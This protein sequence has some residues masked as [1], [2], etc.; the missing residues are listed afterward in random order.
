MLFRKEIKT[1]QKRKKRQNDNNN[2]K[3][4]KK[5]KKKKQPT[6]DLPMIKYTLCVERRLSL[7]PVIFLKNVLPDKDETIQVYHEEEVR[8]ALDVVMT[9]SVRRQFDAMCPLGRTVVLLQ[10]QPRMVYPMLRL[11]C[12]WLEYFLCSF[13]H[14]RQY[15]FPVHVEVMYKQK[16]F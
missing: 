10:E 1:K 6:N 11:K 15:V 3:T 4:T 12:N 16:Y 7:Y 14:F 8:L 13:S 5:N 9:L 2:K